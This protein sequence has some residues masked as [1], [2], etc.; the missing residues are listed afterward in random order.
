MQAFCQV[1]LEAAQ[2][3]FDTCSHTSW[4]CCG[5]SQIVFA[6][7]QR[8]VWHWGLNLCGLMIFLNFHYLP[9]LLFW[10]N[11][12]FRILCMCVCT[13]WGKQLCSVWPGC[14]SGSVEVLQ[15]C[16]WSATPG[17][18][19]WLLTVTFCSTTASATGF[20]PY[21]WQ[22][23]FLN[24]PGRWRWRALSWGGDRLICAELLTDSLK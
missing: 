2:P 19:V 16:W 3:G 4:T 9:V 22:N 14:W 10:N 7:F 13:E 23:F 11:S 15:L 24:L 21:F 18:L 6:A 17:N 12:F 20:K 1:S 5:A 8:T